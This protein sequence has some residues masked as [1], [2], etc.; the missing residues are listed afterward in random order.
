MLNIQLKSCRVCL[1]KKS[2]QEFYR[3]GKGFTTICKLC[4]NKQS[5]AYYRAN[6]E[7]MLLQN[8]EYIAKNLERVQEKRK[9]HYQKNRDYIIKRTYQYKKKRLKEDVCFA[10]SER[11]RDRF[12]KAFK[13]GYRGGIAVRNL[14]C[15]IV[16]LRSHLEM[17]FQP[18]M[19]WENYGTWHIDHIVPLC[20]FDL[21][22][23]RQVQK[24]CHYTNLQPLWAADNL[25][26]GAS[27]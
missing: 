2:E 13:R 16:E 15:S 14:G 7:K 10:L 4:S 21:T 26:K 17:Q 11:I 18:G 6:R 27:C 5:R 20:S 9:E 24:A 8:K 1:E 22:D 12:N 23:D 19:S 25:R 3:K